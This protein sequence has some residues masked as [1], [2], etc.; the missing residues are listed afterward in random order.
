[1]KSKQTKPLYLALTLLAISMLAF[2][3][4]APFC[5]GSNEVNHGKGYRVW[6]AYDE[7]KEKKV[8]E[9]V[10]GIA[11]KYDGIVRYICEAIAAEG[12][13]D[14]FVIVWFP[15]KVNFNDLKSVLKKISGVQKVVK[16]PEGFKWQIALKEW[17]KKSKMEKVI[18]D[19]KGKILDRIRERE[20][21]LAWF[22]EWT[23]QEKLRESLFQTSEV[24][25][26]G[27]FWEHV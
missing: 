13:I 3:L 17:D 21:L 10:N 2:S 9:E 4:L 11:S 6:I 1:M 20:N 27:P 18:K 14:D 7:N 26:I 12:H 15:K 24:H 25:H 23:N 5:L 22:P 8:L 16:G 19:Y